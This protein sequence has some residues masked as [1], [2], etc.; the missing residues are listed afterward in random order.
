MLASHTSAELTEL[1][2]LEEIEPFGE[3]AAHQQLAWL[4]AALFNHWRGEKSD[5]VDVED[6]MPERHVAARKHKAAL[7]NM[8][9]KV[10]AQQFLS[11]G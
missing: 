2:A 3:R 10:R 6:L 8:D 1:Q 11:R 4:S 7:E 9:P 5:P